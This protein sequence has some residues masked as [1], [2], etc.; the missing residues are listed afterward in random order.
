[1]AAVAG[2]VRVRVELNLETYTKN[3]FVFVH[4]S[5]I[6]CGFDDYLPEDVIVRTIL[7]APFDLKEKSVQHINKPVRRGVIDLSALVSHWV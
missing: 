2:S 7:S 3:E 1:M 6:L 4:S 5:E